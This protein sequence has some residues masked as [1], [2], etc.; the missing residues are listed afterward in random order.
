MAIFH[1]LFSK[2]IRGGHTCSVAT[3]AYRS[4]TLLKLRI[5]SPVLKNGTEYTFDYSAKPGIAYSEII[6]P[7]QATKELKNRQ[8]LWQFIEDLEEE[9]N[10]ELACESIFAIPEELTLEEN[11]RLVQDLIEECYKKE[12]LIVDANIHSEHKNNPHVHI[13]SPVRRLDAKGKFGPKLS[14]KHF[15]GHIHNV[16]QKFKDIANQYLEKHGY[17]PICPHDEPRYTQMRPWL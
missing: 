11:I 16:E 12:G 8:Y 13:M 7:K 15:K 5:N 1:H 17:P 6:L 3:A 14:E 4:G 9:R 2:I 10:A